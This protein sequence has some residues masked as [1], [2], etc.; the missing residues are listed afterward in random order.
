MGAIADALLTP[1]TKDV[2]K[3]DLKIVSLKGAAPWA[4]CVK[5]VK[6]VP[7][8]NGYPEPEPL[9]DIAK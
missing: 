3:D 5:S 4:D 2:L 8:G 9:D 1:T 7:E 6:P